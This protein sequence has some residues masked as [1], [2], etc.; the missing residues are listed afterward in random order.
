M[1]KSELIKIL[2]ELPEDLQV[3]YFSS[4]LLL[5]DYY[6]ID[7]VVLIE[8]SDGDERFYLLQ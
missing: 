3:N 5:Q 8:L 7:G 2:Q 1:K 4:Q 6:P